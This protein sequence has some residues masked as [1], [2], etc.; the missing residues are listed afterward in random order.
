MCL[1]LSICNVSAVI[2][3]T[4]HLEAKRH[5]TVDRGGDAMRIRSATLAG[6]AFVAL[7]MADAALAQQDGD[8]QPAEPSGDEIAEIVVTA[9]KRSENLQDVPIAVSALSQNLLDAAGVTSANDL[10]TQIPNL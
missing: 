5:T 4:Q 8:A 2:S 9:Q 7:C 6:C 10:K 3:G 1:S